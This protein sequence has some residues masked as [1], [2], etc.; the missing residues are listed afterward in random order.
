VPVVDIDGIGRVRQ[1]AVHRWSLVALVGV[2]VL[3]AVWYGP[4]TRRDL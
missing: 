1:L 2:A 3:S 4:R